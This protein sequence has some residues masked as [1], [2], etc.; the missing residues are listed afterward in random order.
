MSFP[1]FMSVLISLHNVLQFSLYKSI[2]SLILIPKYY[3]P[4]DAIVNVNIFLTFFSGYSLLAYRNATDFY[5]LILYLVTLLNS[6]ICYHSFCEIFMVWFSTYKF[7]SSV[8]RDNYTSSC[9]IWFI[10]YL[11]Q[12]L[13]LEL[14]A[15]LNES[16]KS[17]DPC[18]VKLLWF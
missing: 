16:G 12:L 5:M 3:L 14:P 6:F 11:A 8:I 1:F 17:R 7:I 4:F 2:T 9:L 10:L 15:L 18:L 13:G